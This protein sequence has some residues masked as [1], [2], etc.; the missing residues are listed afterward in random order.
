VSRIAS[1]PR[2]TLG[3]HEPALLASLVPARRASTVEPVD[4]AFALPLPYV[5]FFVLVRSKMT[6][7]PADGVALVY[8]NDGV[9]S[10]P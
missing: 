9:S 4:V 2:D 1:T 7:S 3:C 5:A 8:V 6:V 10:P